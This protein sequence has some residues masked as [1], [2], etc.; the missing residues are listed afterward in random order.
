MWLS[1]SGQAPGPPPAPT[2]TRVFVFSRLP[3]H[4]RTPCL[5]KRLSL[6]TQ[7][8]R[9]Q[10][11][12]L[13]VTFEAAMLCDIAQGLSYTWTF[14]TSAGWQ[15]ALPPAVHT[16]GQTVTVPS[17]A[18]EPGNYTALAKVGR[19][20]PPARLEQ[21]LPSRRPSRRLSLQTCSVPGKG[22]VV[23]FFNSTDIPLRP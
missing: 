12:T 10:P 6:H 2:Q 21:T 11:L 23:L 5:V 3:W 15:V 1:A 22:F 18:L 14:T 20:L 13:G 4:R 8:W 9:S 17:Y 19:P 7:V 16:H